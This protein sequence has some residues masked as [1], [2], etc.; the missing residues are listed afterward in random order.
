MDTYVVNLI[1]RFFASA[2]TEILDDTCLE[3]SSCGD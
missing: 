2:G 3:D 1:G